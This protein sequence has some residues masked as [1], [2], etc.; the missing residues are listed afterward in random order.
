MAEVYEHAILGGA[1]EDDDNEGE[2]DE[3][4]VTNI[5]PALIVS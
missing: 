1:Q 4:T 3:L 5:L 2:I